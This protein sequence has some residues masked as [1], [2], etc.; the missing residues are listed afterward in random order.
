MSDARV[1]HS[2]RLLDR[3][4]DYGRKPVFHP[5]GHEDGSRDDMDG[6]SIAL[7]VFAG[8]VAVAALVRLM[9][10][11]R[12]QVMAEFRDEVAKE[13]GRRKAAKQNKASPGKAA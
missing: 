3:V 4:P 9:A 10:H 13:K 2:E 6:W 12:S 5:F 1:S 11:S 7:W 8:Y